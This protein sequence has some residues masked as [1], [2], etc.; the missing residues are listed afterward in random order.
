[1]LLM[2]DPTDKEGDQ[3]IG[4]NNGDNWIRVDTIKVFWRFWRQ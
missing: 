3:Y 4:G 1:M 2:L